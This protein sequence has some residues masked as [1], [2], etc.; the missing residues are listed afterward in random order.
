MR[1]TMTMKRRLRKSVYVVGR[2]ASS[3]SRRMTS[4]TEPA[5]GPQKRGMPQK[6]DHGQCEAECRIAGDLQIKVGP[7]RRDNCSDYCLHR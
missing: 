6:R 5:N 3:W 2:R 4:G 7:T 1:K